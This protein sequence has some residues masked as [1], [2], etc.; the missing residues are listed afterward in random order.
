MCYQSGED[1]PD[2]KVQS[3]TGRRICSQDDGLGELGKRRRPAAKEVEVSD[4]VAEDCRRRGSE[5][6]RDEQQHSER[7]E[8]W[9]KLDGRDVGAPC[10]WRSK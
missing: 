7:R 10:G 6:T 9:E 3:R 4:R 8:V 2:K 5:A 1:K